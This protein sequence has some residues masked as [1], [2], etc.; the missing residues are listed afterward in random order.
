MEHVGVSDYMNVLRFVNKHE[1]NMAARYRS[2][3]VDEIQDFGTEELRIL[4]Q[5]VDENENDIF[6]CGDIAQQVQVKQHK[7]RTAGINVLPSNYLR[8]VKNYRNSK[9]ILLAANRMFNSNINRDDFTEEGFELLDPELAN[10]H[11]TEPYVYYAPSFEMELEYALNY[12][13]WCL[14]EGLM[15]KACI[16]LAGFSHFE[17]CRLAEQLQLPILNGDT[18][19]KDEKIVISELNQTKGF[20]FDAVA[21]LNLNS[22]TFR[23]R[24]IQKRKSFVTSRDFTLQ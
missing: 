6:M 15:S 8:I 12:L 5:L 2:I 4:R 23:S 20:E 11:T 3:L 10:F 21:I 7:I 13:K 9:E 17:V 18:D 16:A 22:E 24:I 19:V 1:S 14:N